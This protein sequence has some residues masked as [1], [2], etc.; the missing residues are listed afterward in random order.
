MVPATRASL[1]LCALLLSV[2]VPPLLGAVTVEAFPWRYF[3]ELPPH[4]HYVTHA[5]RSG[6]A[7]LLFSVLG[8]AALCGCL[9]TAG[10]RRRAVPLRRRRPVVLVGVSMLLV[11][12][13]SA[14]SR[15]A[16]V[17]WIHPY[18]FALIWMGYIIALE[19]LLT[20]VSRAR[21]L[22]VGLFLLSA[23]F[24]WS[25][26]VLNRFVQNWSYPALERFSGVEYVL[27]ATVAFSTVLP[28]VDVTFRLLNERFDGGLSVKLPL[29]LAWPLLGTSTL[30][31]F[32]VPVYPN[33]LFV[34]VWV[35]PLVNG[36]VL[37][38]LLGLKGPL[39]ERSIN[40]LARWALAALCCGFLWE[41]WNFR[42]AF[43][44]LYHIPYV[45]QWHLFEMPLLGFAGYLPFGV[46]CGL[47]IE[48]Y[49]I[50]VSERSRQHSSGR[51]SPHGFRS[52]PVH[53]REYRR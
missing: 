11:G 18:S 52:T 22:P 21:P 13:W 41:L 9:F 12:W 38:K 16:S 48:W 46:L 49:F 42:S 15:G 1:A 36:L 40:A 26:E 28:A 50:A 45:E 10:W 32:F 34:F 43:K 27:L 19:G 44:W 8:G 4:T 2:V 47:V 17:E 3:L 33:E 20:E 30:V 53:A 23:A 7:C 5:G 37:A 6:I 35:A 24:W 25:F 29:P 51:Q 39:S 14:W 31:L